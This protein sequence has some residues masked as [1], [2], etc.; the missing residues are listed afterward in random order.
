MT[1]KV[2]KITLMTAWHGTNRFDGLSD[3]IAGDE[4]ETETNTQ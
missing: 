1:K 4:N 3:L 2:E